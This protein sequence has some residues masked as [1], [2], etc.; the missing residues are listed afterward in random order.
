[1]GPW[2]LAAAA[3]ALKRQVSKKPDDSG[4]AA[5]SNYGSGSP[6]PA[7]AAARRKTAA[8]A[9]KAE[10]SA[11]SIRGLSVS[12]SAARLGGEEGAPQRGP[13]EGPPSDA[14]RCWRGCV[15]GVE[16]TFPFTP[17][18][19]Q[20]QLMLKTV[21]AALRA[22]HALLESPTGSGKTLCLL[23]ALL[24]VQQQ[25]QQLMQKQL[26][27]KP[28]SSSLNAIPAAAGLQQTAQQQQAGPAVGKIV[29]ASRTH[30]QLQHVIAELRKTTYAA[31][32]PPDSILQQR[33]QHQQQSEQD[34]KRVPSVIGWSS[35]A[36]TSA[37]AASIPPS[38]AAP[39]AA[40]AVEAE[41][42]ATAA[43][44]AAGA[45]GGLAARS[46]NSSKS[47][48]AAVTSKVKSELSSSSP[49]S[50]A[51]TT[52]AGAAGA[53]AAAGAAGKRQGGCFGPTGAPLRVC[54]LGSRDHMCVHP[55]LR[56]LKGHALTCACKQKIK[57]QSCGFFSS[58]QR[59][60]DSL[61]SLLDAKGPVDIEELRTLALTGP[62][63]FCPY[64]LMREQQTR[65]DVV[66]LPYNYL[67]DGGG[68]NASLLAVDTLNNALLVVDEAHNIERVAEDASCV[69]L[70]QVDVGRCLMA[71]QEAAALLCLD[72]ENQGDAEMPLPSPESVYT[73]GQSLQALDRWLAELELEP[74]TP[75]LSTP[76]RLLPLADFVPAIRT[77]QGGPPMGT[78]ATHCGPLRKLPQGGDCPQS[79]PGIEG[80][81]GFDNKET[82][83]QTLDRTIGLLERRAPALVEGRSNS[84]VEG[85]NTLQHLR[86]ATNI[87]FCE[88]T[89]AQEDLFRVY[90]HPD[91]LHVD[92]GEA[93]A[94][95]ASGSRQEAEAPTT[96]KAK[97][98]TIVCL[99]A[100]PTFA[101]L[102]AR[103][104]RSIICASGTLSP[105]PPLAERM[106]SPSFSISVFLEN[107]QAVSSK[108][109]C[110]L[111]LTAADPVKA[112]AH[113]SSSSSR[114]RCA[115]QL[116]QQTGG[117]GEAHQLLAA[118][119]GRDSES[120]L[121]ALSASLL[122]VCRGVFGGVL[123]FVSSYS[124]LETLVQFLQKGKG[125][126]WLSAL[127][128]VKALFV[129]PRKASELQGL[130]QQFKQQV[131]KDAAALGRSG[132][133][134][135][136]TTTGAL[137]LAV[138]KGKVS[139]GLDLGDMYCRCVMVCGIPY[140]SLK[141]PRVQLKRLFLDQQ[142]TRPSGASVSSGS[143]WYRQ[144]AMRAVNQ[145]RSHFAVGRV[146]RHINDFG[147]IVLADSR[148]SQVYL[149]RDLCG[150]L[151]RSLSPPMELGA[152]AAAAADFFASLP[153]AL[154]RAAEVK[155]Q[156]D[157]SL[158]LPRSAYSWDALEAAA[159]P[160]ETLQAFAFAAA[161]GRHDV[162]AHTLS[163][164]QQQASP[165]NAASR[166]S[167]S[168]GS[169]CGSDRA[170]A[171]DA[172]AAAARRLLQLQGL[173]P[174]KK[175][176]LEAN[177]RGPPSACLVALTNEAIGFTGSNKSTATTQQQQQQQQVQRIHSDNSARGRG[178]GLV[179]SST[180][181]NS[182][183]SGC[184]DGTKSSRSSSSS[185]QMASVEEARETGK[186]LLRSLRE[187]LGR[188]YPAF[189]NLLKQLAA[190]KQ[191]QQPNDRN[192]SSKSGSCQSSS[193]V[194]AARQYAAVV[195]SMCNALLLLP[196]SPTEQQQQDWHVLLS[197]LQR[198][199][200]MLQFIVETYVGP[201]YAA[202]LIKL[203][204][205]KADILL[206]QT[207]AGKRQRQQQQQRDDAE[208]KK[209]LAAAAAKAAAAELGAAD[210]AAATAAT[211][212]TPT[213]G[214]A[215]AP[216]SS[217]TLNDEQPAASV[218]RGAAA[219]SAAAATAAAAASAAADR[220]ELNV[221][222][223]TATGRIDSKTAAAATR[224][225]QQQQQAQQQVQEK[226]Q[227]EQQQQEQRPKEGSVIESECLIC[228]QE[229]PLFKSGM[230]GAAP[231]HCPG[232]SRLQEPRETQI[233]SAC[234][235]P[236]QQQ[237]LRE[238]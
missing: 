220:H 59:S 73:L 131:D 191:Q 84:L 198:R 77:L 123:V 24:A 161:V 136:H 91:A 175:R 222:E 99:S 57:A 83:K 86:H 122:R 157:L 221:L 4:A 205:D 145:A 199:T 120:Y 110:C 61:F 141:D 149:Q 58:Y 186:R 101:S 200:E 128:K 114:R 38:N 106:K 179:K 19:S 49:S 218:A 90:V 98:L 23:C 43:A 113:C 135:P 36:P 95:D 8:A 126:R 140:A 184:A 3:A 201:P 137:L 227:E 52:A 72:Q 82:L 194:G 134:G 104:V 138:C 176:A 192:S 233:P 93:E 151:R 67:F 51:S 37:L 109:I 212:A 164:Q 132:G 111:L 64:Y 230:L 156:Q 162:A 9:T 46:G 232:V 41:E 129:E 22:E 102:A 88:T 224:E 229:R 139:E 153:E 219:G 202:A 225:L 74:S 42:P 223:P 237:Q 142:V 78:P 167:K 103:G 87:I 207:A 119:K 92:F 196:P 174:L 62:Q 171:A 155:T 148:F 178:E 144:E 117:E 127:L 195:E 55:S 172:A 31:L 236:Q 150:W 48:A 16:V 81:F 15:G 54:L 185:G 238:L 96:C 193:A 68:E 211:R 76:H 47:Q 226:Q 13:S 213:R 235:R 27:R 2:T 105:L 26:L 30:T 125:S 80:F 112:A 32:S 56:K 182:S 187:E 228:T 217:S 45:A 197:V 65:S 121:S 71:L 63:S 28:R 75:Q 169:S 158:V 11:L 190:I 188:E 215:V 133:V 20:Q 168:D 206:R 44:A 116:Q 60:R 69:S 29:Y 146:C 152:A 70:R 208:A 10:A 17:Y 40:A 166:D 209:T 50:S 163:K 210:A 5:V 147:L 165:V 35:L 173:R 6:S 143:E 12:T 234:L 177:P 1:M 183:S 66:L 39:A 94:E 53:V 115:L 18:G 203:A 231:R 107:E 97:A 34:R 130:L 79:P 25:Q 204:S 154:L 7:A 124:Q 180:S 100:A 189:C 85:A 216:S 21:E 108:Q 33:Q 118:Y 159:G 89:A 160:A 214:D 170:A 14:K 181:G